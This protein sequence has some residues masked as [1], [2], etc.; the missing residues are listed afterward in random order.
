MQSIMHQ[1]MDDILSSTHICMRMLVSKVLMHTC[2][3]A[4]SPSLS[5]FLALSLSCPL[6]FSPSLSVSL[7][8]RGW[9]KGRYYKGKMHGWGIMRTGIL[10]AKDEKESDTKF[11][12][13][14]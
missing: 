12:R 6:S 11:Q 10:C 14:H 8:D 7:S 9:H 5:L 2:S 4:L 13:A 3:L 1:G